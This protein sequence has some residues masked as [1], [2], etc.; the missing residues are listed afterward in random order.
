M[1]GAMLWTGCPYSTP[2]GLRLGLLP[3]PGPAPLP[4]PLGLAGGTMAAGRRYLMAGR[5]TFTNRQDF[6]TFRPG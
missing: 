5:S 3:G 1:S 6:P 2:L 4:L